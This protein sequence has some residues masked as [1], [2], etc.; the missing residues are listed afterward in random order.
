M[1]FTRIE[2]RA[3][4]DHNLKK[5]TE[6]LEEGTQILKRRAKREDAATISIDEAARIMGVGRN[7]AYAAAKRGQ[8]PVIRV[9][10]RYLV[11]KAAL[12]RLLQEEAA[13]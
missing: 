9:G 13:A 1:F 7:Q 10:R 11:L 6:N 3:E 5:G 4:E 12:K 2:L 8:L